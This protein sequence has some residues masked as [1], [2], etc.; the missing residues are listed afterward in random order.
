MS[1]LEK[2]ACISLY[3]YNTEIK[4]I[5]VTQA[6]NIVDA[7]LSEAIIQSQ[8]VVITGGYVSSQHE[9]AVKIDLLRSK[10]IALSGTP[11]LWNH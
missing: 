5:E 9:N 3:G 6:V 4:T 10:D 11:N 2:S 1:R 7:V 8:E